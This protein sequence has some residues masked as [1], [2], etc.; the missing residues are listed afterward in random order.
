MFFVREGS[1]TNVLLDTPSSRSGEAMGFVL[2]GSGRDPG[3]GPEA[4]WSAGEQGTEG[5]CGCPGEFGDSPGPRFTSR[6]DGCVVKSPLCKGQKPL[7]FALDDG[8]TRKGRRRRRERGCF[9]RKRDWP[10]SARM[11]EVDA[12]ILP[13]S[14]RAFGGYESVGYSCQCSA[15]AEAG[16]G[17]SNC[18]LRRGE[19]TVARYRQS[20]PQHAA[21]YGQGV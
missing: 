4:Q 20:Q 16:T 15:P 2:A 8:T 10:L 18:V 14:A 6:S 9:H 13:A 1:V 5:K 12:P 17:G 3:G 21:V 7:T 19:C 11:N